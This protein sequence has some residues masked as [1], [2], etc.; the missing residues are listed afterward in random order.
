MIWT[1][2]DDKRDAA[3]EAVVIRARDPI[4]VG[5]DETTTGAMTKLRT[6]LGVVLVWLDVDAMIRLCCVACTI[7]AK[8]KLS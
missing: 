6:V 2:V 4:P 3:F 1:R 8:R 5:P 7:G